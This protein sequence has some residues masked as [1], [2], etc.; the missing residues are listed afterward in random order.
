MRGGENSARGNLGLSL[1][2]GCRGVDLALAERATL[3]AGWYAEIYPDGLLIGIP[4]SPATRP[5]NAGL[6][7][8]P[9]LALQVAPWQRVRFIASIAAPFIQIGD[10][11]RDMGRSLAY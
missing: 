11:E 6:L 10:F 7:T 5:H 4:G 9:T 2:P 1:S 8:G 3:S